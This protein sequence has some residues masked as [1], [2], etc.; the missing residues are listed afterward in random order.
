MKKLLFSLFLLIIVFVSAQND[1][2]TGAINLPVGTNFTSGAITANNN[3]ATT[4]GTPPTCTS[5][6]VDNVW[7]KATVPQSG[8]LT[9]EMREVSGTSFLY[10]VITVY[11]GMCNSLTQISCKDYGYNVP[12]VFNGRTPGEIIYISVWKL[13]SNISNGAFKISAFDPAPPANDPCSG[14][15]SLTVGTDF[16]SGAINVDNT[17]ATPDGSIPS[18]Q[19]STTDNIWFKVIV[20]QMVI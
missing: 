1:N 16:N 18:C 12:L 19:T 6:A 15:I 4:D 8:N 10:P 17:G 13:N 14:A 3:G 11:T 2:C 9:I 5:V 7:F 20:P